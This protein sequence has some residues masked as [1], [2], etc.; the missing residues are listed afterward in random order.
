MRS[1]GRRQHKSPLTDVLKQIL[2]RRIIY[3]ISIATVLEHSDC[4]EQHA[5]NGENVSKESEDHLVKPL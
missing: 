3:S 5:N 1:P 2:S 4:S